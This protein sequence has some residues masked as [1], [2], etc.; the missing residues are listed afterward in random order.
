[1]SLER[2]KRQQA[3]PIILR[4]LPDL[5]RLGEVLERGTDTEGK[6]EI[7]AIVD[8]VRDM[9]QDP[10]LIEFS[11]LD[12]IKGLGKDGPPNR[13]RDGCGGSRAMKREF[14]VHQ[15][16]CT[17]DQARLA[18]LVCNGTESSECA[19]PMNQI[20]EAFC[21]RWEV[22][23]PFHGLGDFRSK[24]ETDNQEFC[25]LIL[26]AEEN[27]TKMKN[28]SAPSPDRISKKANMWSA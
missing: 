15:R 4:S 27:L 9:D 7:R 10:G 2:E 21:E 20:Y 1:M 22:A 13:A 28:G 19:L 25:T 23:G 8:L 17:R 6:N 16:L 5:I 11:A 18:V 3:N 12:I 14:P 24:A 26:A